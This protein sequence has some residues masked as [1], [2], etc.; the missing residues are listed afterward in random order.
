VTSDGDTLVDLLSERELQSE[1]LTSALSTLFSHKQKD[2]AGRPPTAAELAR[3]DGFNP[4]VPGAAERNIAREA[5][6]LARRSDHEE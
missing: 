3:R 2:L 1:V 4:L 5:R 6:G